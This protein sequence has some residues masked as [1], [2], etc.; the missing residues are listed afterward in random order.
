MDIIQ[1]MILQRFTDGSKVAVVPGAGFGAPDH[2]RVSYAT[3][4]GLIKKHL[5]NK[6]VRSK[7]K[8]LSNS[9]HGAIRC[10]HL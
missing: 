5:Q 2:V 1:L 7:K 3:S 8:W 9:L 10:F 6:K 4:R